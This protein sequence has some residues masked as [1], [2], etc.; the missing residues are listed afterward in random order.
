M[1][2]VFGTTWNN[3]SGKYH[4][5]GILSSE[6]EIVPTR[7]SFVRRFNQPLSE[8]KYYCTLEKAE[9]LLHLYMRK[10]KVECEMS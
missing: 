5:R 10:E 6:D 3:E 4:R 9:T 8:Q 1:S 7:Y 2:S